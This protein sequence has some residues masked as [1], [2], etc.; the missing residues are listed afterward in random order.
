MDSLTVSA[1][2]LALY[3]YLKSKEKET[4][5]GPAMVFVTDSFTLAN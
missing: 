4:N 2:G 3:S 1:F 5:V